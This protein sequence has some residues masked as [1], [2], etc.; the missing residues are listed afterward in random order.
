MARDLPNPVTVDAGDMLGSSDLKRKS[1]IPEQVAKKAEVMADFMK[2]HPPAAAALGDLDLLLGAGEARR[3]LGD[4]G[5]ALV[6]TNVTFADGAPKTI[7]FASFEAG[8]WKFVAL[9]VFS[10][11]SVAAVEG[12]QWRDPLEAI[13]AAR[14]AAGPHDFSLVSS[15]GLDEAAMRRIAERADFLKILLDG[16]GK[17]RLRHASV[18]TK[19]LVVTPPARGSDLLVAE[20]HLLRGAPSFYD[21]KRFETAFRRKED[22]ETEAAGAR[23]SHIARFRELHLDGTYPNDPD[24]SKLLADYKSWSREHARASAP[25]SAGATPYRG[26]AACAE[27]HPAQ[28]A[29]WLAT[30]HAKAWETLEKAE[31]GGADDPECVSCHT[32]GFLLPGGPSRIEDT[33]PL[34]GVQ[35][36]SCHVP[37]GAHP[38]SRFGK[39]NEETCVVCHSETRDPNFDF[40]KYLP[41][42]TCTKAHDPQKNRVPR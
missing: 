14:A 17:V 6:A 28:H 12:A 15:H 42:A 8:G 11:K 37:K 2:L 32:S 19:T 40:K 10:R 36:E 29:N 26:A 27:C 21:A 34:R 31:E 3:L 25:A 33:V 22:V 35:C 4:R 38:G 9:N 23:R 39:V 30:Y 7:P 24:A 41:Y 5:I 13:D 20:L 1:A 18:V 16:D